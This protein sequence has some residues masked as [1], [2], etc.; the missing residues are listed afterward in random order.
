MCCLASGPQRKGDLGDESSGT[1]LVG[2]HERIRNRVESLGVG[3]GKRRRLPAPR[4]PGLAIQRPVRSRGGQHVPRGPPCGWGVSGAAGAG[5]A[6]QAP[7]V[8]SLSR[9]LS[10]PLFQ[11]CAAPFAS[12]TGSVFSLPRNSCFYEQGQTPGGQEFY[13]SVISI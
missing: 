2:Q 3:L 13:L 12:P 5:P 10:L 9:L 6:S 8:C 11:K 1:E 4:S 7:A